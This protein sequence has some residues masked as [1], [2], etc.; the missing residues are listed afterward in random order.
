MRQSIILRTM[1]YSP[2]RKTNGAQVSPADPACCPQSNADA[3]L[4][5]WSNFCIINGVALV[6]A[7]T[8]GAFISGIAS[9]E[10]MNS[11][12]RLAA[13]GC[14][15]AMIAVGKAACRNARPTS[16]GLNMLKPSPP[17]SILPG[18]TAINPP[19]AVIHRGNPGGRTKPSRMPVITTEKSPTD[20][21]FFEILQAICSVSTQE[22]VETINSASA[23]TPNSHTAYA[24]MGSSA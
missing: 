21:S 16:A 4:E 15:Y 1:R 17:N 5:T 23:L 18:A 2:H 9:V 13:S 6:S 3:R 10:G 14:V 20:V 19:T 11:E 8:A 22:P 12:K 24:Q 7:A